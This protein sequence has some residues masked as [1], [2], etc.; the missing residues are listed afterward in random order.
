MGQNV[1]VAGVGMTKFTKPGEHDPY[2][3]S[4]SA[5]VRDALADAGIAYGAV[6]HAYA[7]YDY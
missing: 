5:A 2:P 1:Y 3:I 7:G 6:Q 4:G